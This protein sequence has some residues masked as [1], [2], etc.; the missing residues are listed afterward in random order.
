MTMK[1]AN[2]F[3][4]FPSNS[5]VCFFSRHLDS[6]TFFFS[7]RNNELRSRWITLEMKLVNKKWRK[8]LQL[9][10]QSFLSGISCFRTNFKFR[11]FFVRKFV[12]LLESIQAIK[13]FLFVSNDQKFYAS[14][15]TDLSIWVTK[16]KFPDWL[17]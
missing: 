3:T 9:Q 15:G 5:N 7:R 6:S 1:L 2:G 16:I 4:A 13:I 10:A 11:L 8:N 17:S 12:V 14:W